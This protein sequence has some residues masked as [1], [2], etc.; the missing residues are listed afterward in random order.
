[1]PG[2]NIQDWSTTAANNANSDSAIT[3]AEGQAR[4]S[5]NNSARSMMAAHAK[6]RNLLNG[7]II[8]TGTT[9]AQAFFSG[10][11]YTTVPTG[12]RVLLKIGPSLTN[13]GAATLE[14]DGLGAVAIK[15]Q[16]GADIGAGALT[17]D[18]RAEFIY[19]G[20]NWILLA[21][22]TAPTAAAGDRDTSIANTA[23]VGAEVPAILAARAMFRANMAVGMSGFGVSIPATVIFGSEVID[24]G[25]F[26]DGSAAWTPPAGRVLLMANLVLGADASG[27]II[28]V[29]FWKNVATA[30]MRG[31]T[32][33]GSGVVIGG[34]DVTTVDVANGT[35]NY[36]VV[37]TFDRAGGAIASGTFAGMLM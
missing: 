7:S 10:L 27:A 3:W 2:E 18:T 23:W 25:G 4:A 35:D 29:E 31:V 12:M 14:M 8:T 24:I 5:V 19:S 32:V 9:N 13:T 26:Y 30:G 28:N 20:T 37:V 22:M 16:L 11:D 36:R 6:Q 33:I 34:I 17:A 15:D 1:M 21:T